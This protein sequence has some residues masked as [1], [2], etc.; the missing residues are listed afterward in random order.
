MYYHV[1]G[2]FSIFCRWVTVRRCTSGI[3]GQTL[4]WSTDISIEWVDIDGMGTLYGFSDNDD[5]GGQI[6]D[7]GFDF[8]FLG[9][10]IQ[11]MHYKCKRLG[12]FWK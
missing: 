11:P 5:A 8:P 2:C 7:I 6:V 10:N 1:F 12:W 4:I 9:V 3:S